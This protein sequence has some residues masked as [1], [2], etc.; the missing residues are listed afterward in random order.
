MVRLG[1]MAV[2]VL[3]SSAEF[4]RD[5]AVPREFQRLNPCPSTG[6]T[7]G[8]CPGWE[9]DHVVPLCRG[10]ADTVGNMQWLTIEAHKLK[11]RGDC[12]ALP[13]S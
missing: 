2:V 11:T 5:P 8:A 9:R 6:R 10:G 4:A 7:S 1:T 3:L 12:R 13:G